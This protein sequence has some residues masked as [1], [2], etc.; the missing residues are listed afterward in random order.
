M[1]GV[2]VNIYFLPDLRRGRGE[3]GASPGLRLLHKALE[4][5][6][7]HATIDFLSQV[8]KQQPSLQSDHLMGYF[9]ECEVPLPGPL[10]HMHNGGVSARSTG[11][12]SNLTLSSF[13]VSTF[14]VS[15]HLRDSL[16]V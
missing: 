9:A 5:T 4:L 11:S 14:I 2:T 3:K 15:K 6:S 16:V 10:L 13:Q 1:K 8:M 12:A 7:H